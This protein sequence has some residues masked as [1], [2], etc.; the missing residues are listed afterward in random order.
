M[1]MRM[2]TVEYS[3]GHKCIDNGLGDYKLLCPDYPDIAYF[4][5]FRIARTEVPQKACP[6][7]LRLIGRVLS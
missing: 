7:C 1:T 2:A 3:S 6:L 4:V 5:P